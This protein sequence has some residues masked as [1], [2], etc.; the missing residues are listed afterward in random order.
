MDGTGIRLVLPE[1]CRE[2]KPRKM[3]RHS[4]KGITVQLVQSSTPFTGTLIDFSTESFRVDITANPPQTFQWINPE[5]PVNIIFSDKNEMLYSGECRIIKQ[6]NGHRTR[7][8]VLEPLNYQIRR[9]KP[10]E[11]RS[12]RM[13]LLP[14]PNIIFKHPF[15]QHVCSLKVMDL[16]GSGFSVEE[17]IRNAVILPGMIIPEL[18]LSFADISSFKCKV[19]AV[20]RNIMEE[21][22]GGWVKC[23]IAILDMDLEAH[24]RVLALLNHA[25]DGNS[26]IC[27]RVNMDDLWDF[28]FESGFI[29]PKKYAFLEAN[30]EKIKK[31]YNRLYTQNQKIA[32]HF[33]YQDKGRI[34]GHVAMLRFY[35]NAWLIHHHAARN[36]GIKRSGI[37]VLDQIGRFSNASHS[38][39]S[40]H[41]NYLFCYFRPENKFP[42]RIFGGVARDIRDPKASSLDTFAYFHY[43]KASQNEL[44]LPE[45]WRLINTESE[46]LI[47]FGRCYEHKS[48][49]LMLDALDLKPEMI[50]RDTLSKEYQTQSFKRERH[51]F[52]LKNDV[53]LMAIF[54]ANVSDV[55]LN[56]SDFT[57]CIKVF[58]LDSKGLSKNILYQTLSHLSAKFDQD[59]ISVLL[60]PVSF[61]EAQFVPYEKLYQMWVL[62]TQYGDQY[63][64]SL[65]GL[66]KGISS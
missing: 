4:C 31:T 26:Y 22:T 33:I 50:G 23:G 64:R 7:S 61:A 5:S 24:G 25:K 40:L 19:Q 66:F 35:E 6:T 18:E 49:G 17:D 59:E 44:R 57:N 20:Y 47:E 11:F 62:N 37:A 16:S 15:T 55:G 58:V 12:L 2:V 43:Q 29:Y 60:Y 41:M 45:P 48:G 54:M 56:M 52:S 3:R 53:D 9:F 8:F 13:E 1:T 34:L 65:K 42:N 51:L 14:S 21:E 38:L 30:K 10:K 28:F 63:F 39:Y 46:D 32:R 27:N 36:P